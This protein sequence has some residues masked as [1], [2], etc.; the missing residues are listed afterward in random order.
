MFPS[1]IQCTIPKLLIL[2]DKIHQ[3]FCQ[4][5]Y[6]IFLF[7]LSN[8]IKIPTNWTESYVIDADGFIL[9]YSVANKNS[10]KL[11]ETLN[12]KIINETQNNNIPR[13]VVGNK[14]D[15]Q[16]SERCI[17]EDEGRKLAEKLGLMN[18]ISFSILLKNEK[19]FT[20]K[21]L[22][23]G[24][25]FFEVSA[26]LNENVENVFL[27]LL[28]RIEKVPLEKAKAGGCNVM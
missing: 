23:I 12:D 8:P 18:H 1:I 15:V 6:F 24:C 13:V 5:I 16:E 22:E 25:S 11:I 9:V 10:F 7:V 28:A 27:T 14:A 17:S 21:N 2:L 4:V 19:K 26:K 3:A 20:K